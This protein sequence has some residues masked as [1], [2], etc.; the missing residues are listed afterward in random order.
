[1]SADPDG[2]ASLRAERARASF[3]SDELEAELR[4]GTDAVAARRALLTQLQADPVLGAG[5]LDDAFLSRE[6]KFEVRLERAARVRAVHLR[7]ADASRL[8]TYD[9]LRL[10]R[11]G[12]VLEKAGGFALHIG[13]FMPT[14]ELLGT[15]EQAREW[16]PLARS[17]AILG[18]YA[19]SELGHGTNLARLETTATFDP[20]S[21]A[22]V[23][24]SP[25]VTSTKWW[26]GGLGKTSTHAVVMANLQL[27]GQWRGQHAFL[28]QLRDLRTHAPLTGVDLGDIGPKM[29]Y[30]SV[31]NGFLRLT[32]VSVPRAQLLQRHARV[33]RDGSYTLLSSEP[34]A[35]YGTMLVIRVYL[36]DEASL[37]L[38]HATTVATR[39]SAVRRQGGAGAVERQLLDYA[40]QQARLL[41]LVAAAYAT[42]FA[43]KDVRDAYDGYRTHGRGLPQLHAH[44]AALKAYATA[45]AAAGIETCRLLC[46]GHGYSL[47]SG[48]PDLFCE[49][50]PSQT[51]EGDNNVMLLQVLGGGVRGWA[52]GAYT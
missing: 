31:D 24:H 33:G 48:L 40:T 47:A 45:T 36:V 2:V 1:M 10:H 38:Q 37:A 11:E 49:F 29:G 28:V 9:S 17:C 14:I 42:H 18:T 51:Y 19:Q 20:A 15:E 27:G 50:T 8:R 32:H 7:G 34:K 41:P 12:G 3:N 5:R 22:F 52:T 21:D 30:A 16:L 46:G 4:G 35:V 23:L 6:Q 43:A 39:Y 25:T 13:M 44:S 26:P